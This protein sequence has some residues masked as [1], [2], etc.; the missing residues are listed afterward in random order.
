M[1][2]LVRDLQTDRH[3]KIRSF[4][5]EDNALIAVLLA[6]VDLEWTIRRTIDAMTKTDVS[7]KLISGLE[8]YKKEWQMICVQQ[9]GMQTL[10]VIVDDWR[11]L[12]EYYQIRHDIIHGRTGST[13]LDYASPRVEA[14]LEAA[15]S[16][17]IAGKAA[18]ADPYALARS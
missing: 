8:N 10:D 6:A 16:I 7:D 12:K 17:A 2:F 13:T 18:G 9:G 5:D 11:L 4:L 3:R 1:K 14:M 15:K